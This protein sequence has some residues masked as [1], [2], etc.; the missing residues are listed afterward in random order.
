MSTAKSTVKSKPSRKKEGVVKKMR[1]FDMSPA[2]KVVYYPDFEGLPIPEGSKLTKELIKNAVDG[3]KNFNACAWYAK[4]TDI[5]P[6]RIKASHT[7]CHAGLNDTYKNSWYLDL[8]KWN[9]LTKDSIP[10]AK[11]I[12]QM[13]VSKDSPW[14]DALENAYILWDKEEDRL[15]GIYLENFGKDIPKDCFRLFINLMIAIRCVSEHRSMRD[16]WK[17]KKPP[18]NTLLGW[19]ISLDLV[20]MGH[21][22][23]SRHGR[24][25]SWLKDLFLKRHSLKAYGGKDA[26]SSYGNSVYKGGN[27]LNAT[28]D[29]IIEVEKEMGYASV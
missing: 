25:K 1:E 4:E 13:L 7:A 2:G 19:F 21:D 22:W 16:S 6:D 14:A 18:T 11:K 20:I 29:D 23:A 27:G 9:P 5:L 24:D 12:Y 17:L 8:V 15:L 26:V 10:N 28:V 3:M